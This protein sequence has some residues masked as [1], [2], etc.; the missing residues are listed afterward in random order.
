VIIR[1]ATVNDLSSVVR[2][3]NAL[4]PTTTVAWTET[5]QTLDERRRWFD[6]QLAD[7]F[8][9]LVAE[10]DRAVVGFCSYTHFRGA[11]VW[12]G[13]SLTVEHTIHVAQQHWGMGIGR[14][15]LYELLK[16]ARA[17]EL[18]VMVGAIDSSNTA[19]IDF[20]SRLGFAEVARMPQIGHKFGKW[21][22]LVLMQLVLD[23]RSA[24]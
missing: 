10:Y 22:D 1:D 9:V 5:P 19:S 24:P 18:H 2:L 6:R 8:P 23:D 15:L 13:Y 17:A 12:S 20:H 14:L 7:G 4:I 21:L 11:G 16:R 3:Y